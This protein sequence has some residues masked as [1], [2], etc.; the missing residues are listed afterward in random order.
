M[1]VLVRKPKLQYFPVPKSGCTSVKHAMWEIENGRPFEV[2]RVGDEFVNIHSVHKGYGTTPWREEYRDRGPLLYNF[3]VVRDPVKRVLSCY[4]NRVLYKN[5]LTR[6]GLRS[7]LPSHVP[8]DPSA[9]EFFLHL[10]I[11]QQASKSVDHHSR[12][13]LY[14][15]G[16]DLSFYD[17]IYGIHQMD[18]LAV[19]L[20]ER[21]GKPVTIPHKQTGGPAI[22]LNT[23]SQELRDKV[24]TQYTADY[25]AL[26]EVFE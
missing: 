20:S 11:Y 23:I 16:S 2:F 26:S 24:A 19:F 12:P 17:R 13:A 5:D 4:T 18:E 3:S 1:P 14:F 6:L 21:V 10:P 25:E 7:S 9:E 22:K 8:L 15:L